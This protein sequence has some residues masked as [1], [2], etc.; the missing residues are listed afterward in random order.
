MVVATED[1]WRD[2]SDLTD[3]FYIHTYTPFIF[4]VNYFFKFRIF[5]CLVKKKHT[6]IGQLVIR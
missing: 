4:I 5:L 1:S 6:S 2:L 3:L